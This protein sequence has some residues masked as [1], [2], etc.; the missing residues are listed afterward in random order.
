[1]K[2]ILIVCTGNVCR[3][4]MAAIL[5]KDLAR[6]NGADGLDVES[7]G[8]WATDGQPASGL[9][10]TLMAERGL[11]L[12]RHRARTVTSRDMEDASLILVM[13]DNQRQA[14][15][16]E[17]PMHRSR[18]H[19]LAEVEGQR[20]DIVDPYGGTRED[21]RACAADL[22]HLLQVGYHQILRWAEFSPSNSSSPAAS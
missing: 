10:Q 11:D 9:A 7:A 5:L 18:I 21:Y 1:M 19:L 16:A 2:H 17:F 12:A 3:S 13:T 14:L 15:S 22:E 6:R 4:P 8:T 20:R